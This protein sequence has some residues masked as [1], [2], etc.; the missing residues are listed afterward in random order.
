ML[1][2]F[3]HVTEDVINSS[4]QRLDR[5]LQSLVPHLLRERQSFFGKT[6]RHPKLTQLRIR[7]R[8]RLDGQRL[9]I[10]IAGSLKERNSLLVFDDSCTL[11]SGS[12]F[13]LELLCL[14][15]TSLSCYVSGV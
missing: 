8:H 4:E 1:L 9:A 11:V 12:G 5:R 6:Q 13:C 15:E 10:N 3:G 7:Q 14:F 2:G